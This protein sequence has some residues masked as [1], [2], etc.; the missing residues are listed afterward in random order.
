MIKGDKI[1]LIKKMGI[2]DKIGEEYE[3][4]DISKEGVIS[5]RFDDCNLGYMSYDEY[6]KYFELVETNE[7]INEEV[8]DIDL[9]ALFTWCKDNDKPFYPKLYFNIMAN[10]KL[11]NS[12]LCSYSNRLC[13]RQYRN[14][15]FKDSDFSD[16]KILI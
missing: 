12:T 13:L 16:M 11:S 1:R 7:K 15:T 10:N 5:F 3:I 9:T 14:K 2:L 8:S 4:I 6:E